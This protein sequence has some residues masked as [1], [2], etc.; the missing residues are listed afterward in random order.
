MHAM[1]HTAIEI[2]RTDQSKIGKELQRKG[3]DRKMEI[4]HER[5]KERLIRKMDELHKWQIDWRA[6]T[7]R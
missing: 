4:D 7:M 5:V 2:N 3:K 6:R 1:T